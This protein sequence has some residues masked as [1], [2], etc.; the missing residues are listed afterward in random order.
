MSSV[1][2]RSRLFGAITVAVLSA[3]AVLTGATSATAVD[4]PFSVTA[5]GE[6][7]TTSDRSPVFSGFGEEGATVTVTTATGDAAAVSTTVLADGSWTA[8]PLVFGPNVSASQRG[9]VTHTNPGGVIETITRNFFMPFVTPTNAIILTNGPLNGMTLS[10]TK[11]VVEGTA[12]VGS[13]LAL[14]TSESG[15]DFVP[16]TVGASGTFSYELRVER[17]PGTFGITVLGTLAGVPLVSDGVI[18]A[19]APYLAAP[20]IVSPAS[21]ATV[22]GSSVT[23][24]GT[25][26]AGQKLVV[27][28]YVPDLP[29]EE[30]LKYSKISDEVV[31]D[32]Q[33]RWS[34]TISSLLPADY[35][36][37]AAL[38][39]SDVDFGAVIS[40]FSAETKF[41]LAAAL[42][43]TGSNAADVLPVGVLLM[44]A[45]SALLVIRRRVRATP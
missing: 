4:L 8:P 26:I 45:G 5:P 43:N 29:L 30:H 34:A 1:S 28:I 7:T 27:S 6:L 44:L 38:V 31:V 20:V 23:F 33:G 40:E 2:V 36:V 18:Y 11:L 9:I 21:G 37:F 24:S 16:I 13:E 25:A 19:R 15:N 32:A 3:A 41:R 12:P 14:Y 10:S 17:G 22:V 39:E 35:T 42:P